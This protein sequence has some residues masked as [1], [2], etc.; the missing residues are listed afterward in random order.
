MASADISP[1]TLLLVEKRFLPMPTAVECGLAGG[2]GQ[3]HDR[4]E[5]CLQLALRSYL[6]VSM[7]FLSLY[8]PRSRVNPGKKLLP[9]LTLPSFRMPC[10]AYFCC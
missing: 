2:V 10:C 8:L 1:G 6:I 4:I 5:Y 7:S 3:V 9:F